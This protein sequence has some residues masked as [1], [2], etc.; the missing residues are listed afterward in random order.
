[1]LSR[2]NQMVKVKQD[3]SL[4]TDFA[5][6]V[7]FGGSG[8]CMSYFGSDMV[9][10]ES[11]KRGFATMFQALGMLIGASTGAAVSLIIE[12]FNVQ[13][14]YNLYELYTDLH[15]KLKSNLAKDL[16]WLDIECLLSIPQEAYSEKI[17]QKVKSVLAQQSLFKENNNQITF[18]EKNSLNIQF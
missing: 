18:E 3:F 2:T 5:M 8:S 7:I 6:R 15:T 16:D 17:Q 10:D 11:L 12:N 13:T 4:A 14:L 9:V 1:V